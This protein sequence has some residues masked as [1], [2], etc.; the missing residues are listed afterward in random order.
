M[1]A[2]LATRSNSPSVASY[3]TFSVSNEAQTIDEEAIVLFLGGFIAMVI[4]GPGRHCLALSTE[5]I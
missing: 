3:T 5:C 2:A 1:Q 4:M